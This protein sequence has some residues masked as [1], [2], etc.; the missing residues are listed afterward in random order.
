MEKQGES[1]EKVLEFPKKNVRR[2]VVRTHNKCYQ[3]LKE[4]VFEQMVDGHQTELEPTNS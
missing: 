2:I 3:C 1:L 4:E